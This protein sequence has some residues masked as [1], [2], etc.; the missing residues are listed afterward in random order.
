MYTLLRCKVTGCIHKS[1]RCNRTLTLRHWSN[2]LLA[3]SYRSVGQNTASVLTDFWPW[4]STQL[5]P[6]WY[7]RGSSCW[8]CVEKISLPL[9]KCCISKLPFLKNWHGSTNTTWPLC[10]LHKQA[11]M[12]PSPNKGDAICVSNPTNP[13]WLK[14]RPRYIRVLEIER[15]QNS[16]Q[17]MLNSNISFITGKNSKILHQTTHNLYQ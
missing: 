16:V 5:C 10:V 15:G 6:A 4:T 1:R 8:S 9:E 14:P 13:T 3:V 2:M 17:N 12:T 7:H 11:D